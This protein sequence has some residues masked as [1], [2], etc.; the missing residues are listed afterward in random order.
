VIRGNAVHLLSL[1]RHSTEEVST[2]HHD[3]NLDLEGAN[4]G[5]FGGYFVHASGIHAETLACGQRFTGQ[6][7]KN[8]FEDGL[9]H[10]VVVIPQLGYRS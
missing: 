6:L 5:E 4:F 2:A 7:E 3:G 1:L 8:A 10:E 9:R